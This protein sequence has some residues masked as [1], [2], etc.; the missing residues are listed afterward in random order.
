MAAIRSVGNKTEARLRK[1]V[2]RL[3]LR[4]RKYPRNLPGRP[5]FVFPSA[6]VAVFVD[7]DFW[8]GR[9]LIERGLEALRERVRNRPYWVS[10]LR[11]RVARDRLVTRELERNGWLVLRFW[12]SDVRDDIDSAVD[13][14]RIA[15][16]RRST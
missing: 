1:S 14:I 8:H 7:G 12:E 2:H 5:D 16:G 6:R 11:A 4:Y 9:I 13:Q 3:G 15:V 10:K